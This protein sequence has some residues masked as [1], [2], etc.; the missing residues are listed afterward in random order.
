MFVIDSI[1]D[2]E[3]KAKTKEKATCR[4]ECHRE[5]PAHMADPITP[6]ELQAMACIRR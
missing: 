2:V 1:I 4:E 5:I 3:K 6:E